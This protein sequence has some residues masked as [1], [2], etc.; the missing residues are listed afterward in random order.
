MRRL[1]SF[2]TCGEMHGVDRRVANL[3]LD[4]SYHG[5]SRVLRD[6]VEAALCQST[7][8]LAASGRPSGVFFP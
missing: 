5:N 4:R 6:G 3:E 7:I 1:R 8:V 2:C